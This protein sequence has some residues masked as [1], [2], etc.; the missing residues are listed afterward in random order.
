METPL[1]ESK[2]MPTLA[3]I[4]VL[5]IYFEFTIGVL[6]V[7]LSSGVENPGKCARKFDWRGFKELN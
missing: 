5:F 3:R 2:M 1:G 7:F 4:L 6:S